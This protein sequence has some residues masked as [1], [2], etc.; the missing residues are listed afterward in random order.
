MFPSATYTTQAIMIYIPNTLFS[1]VTKGKGW[2][3]KGLG[4]RVEGSLYFFSQRCLLFLLRRK[5]IF[6]AVP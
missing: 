5:K 1:S 4:R 6:K 3:E 2:V